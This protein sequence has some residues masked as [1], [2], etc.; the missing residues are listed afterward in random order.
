[1]NGNVGSSL[2]GRSNR[3]WGPLPDDG[4]APGR[5]S[6]CTLCTNFIR[7]HSLFTLAS[8]PARRFL[9]RHHRSA[10]QREKISH[11]HTLG[12]ALVS[13]SAGKCMAPCAFIV[14]Y[15]VKLP[16]SRLLAPFH[17]PSSGNNFRFA[18]HSPPT[19]TTGARSPVSQRR[20]KCVRSHILR[21]GTSDHVQPHHC[22]F[23]ILALESL[24]TGDPLVSPAR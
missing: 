1:M 12:S 4:W 18:R 24:I 10:A 6:G 22:Y 23:G 17:Y 2:A 3:N 8:C 16:T 13:R 5:L 20:R 11:P 14:T 9:H 21:M 19:N 15:V 7:A